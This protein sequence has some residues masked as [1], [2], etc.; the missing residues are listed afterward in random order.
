M[1]LTKEQRTYIQHKLRAMYNTKINSLPKQATSYPSDRPRVSYNPEIN[2]A[3]QL[4]QEEWEKE[5]K[6]YQLLCKPIDLAFEKANE[7]LLFTENYEA[8]Q[9]LLKSF[10]EELA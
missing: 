4:I 5:T 3:L 7:Q 8:V 6:A 2:A 9:N 1:K 10:E